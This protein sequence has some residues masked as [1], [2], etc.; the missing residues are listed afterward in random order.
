MFLSDIYIN[1]IIFFYIDCSNKNK[2]IP[3]SEK[4]K[5]RQTNHQILYKRKHFVDH[6]CFFQGVPLSGIWGATRIQGAVKLTKFEI[7][8]KSIR[9]ATQVKLPQKLIKVAALIETDP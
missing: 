3:K 4:L 5:H 1:L 7:D 2:I 6:F 9:V 8:V